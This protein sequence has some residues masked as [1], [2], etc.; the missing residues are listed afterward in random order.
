MICPK[1]N[2]NHVQK[3]GEHNGL[4]RYRCMNCNERFDGG[5]Y[6]DNY[7]MHFNKK[8]KITDRNKLTRDNYCTPSSKLSAATTRMIR[9]INKF[10]KDVSFYRVYTTIPNDVFEDDEHYTSEW[11]EDHYRDC[12]ENFDLN[13]KYFASL[14]HDEFEKSL[15]SFV[16][17]NRF[18]E[19]KDLTELNFSGTYILVLDEYKQVY[20]GVS[21]NIEKRIK[22]HWNRRKEFDRLIFGTVEDSILSIDSFG[23]LDTTRIF[24]KRGSSNFMFSSEESYVKKFNKKFLLNRVAGGIN[25][26]DNDTIRDMQLFAT[27]RQRKL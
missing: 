14:N 22:S 24:Y 9:R 16:K 6:V 8:I 12:M 25:D 10:Y 26:E 11:V 2:S 23:P 18:K 13:M 7:L 5:K 19:T 17:K 15:N 3:N 20:I 21:E 4:Q 1:C 27:R